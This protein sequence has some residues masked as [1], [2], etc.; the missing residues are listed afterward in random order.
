MNHILMPPI[1]L[2][3]RPGFERGLAGGESR[4]VAMR[5]R[6]VAIVCGLAVVILSQLAGAANGTWNV[7]A[8]GSWTN[9]ANWTPVGTPNGQGQIAALTNN[10][11]NNR[12]VTLDAAITVGTLIVGDNNNTHGFTLNNG[13]APGGLTFDVASGSAVLRKM[14]RAGGTD[15]IGA[16]ITLADNL[17]ATNNVTGSL[18]LNGAIGESAAG[19]SITF[20]GV[21]GS[22]FNLT[23][24]NSYSGGTTVRNNVRLILS[25]SANALGLG[26]ATVLSNGQ[27]WMN[28]ALTFTN[29]LTLNGIGWSEGSGFLGAIRFAA[30]AVAS[31]PVTLGSDVR[32]SAWGAGDAG[33]ISGGIDGGYGLEKTGAG[34]LTL[35]GANTYT[36]G[37][38]IR[39]INS[40]AGTLVLDYTAQNNSKISSTAGM[41]ISNGTLR[42]VGN[43]A[44]YTQ[45]VAGL[46]LEA[47]GYSQIVN[48]NAGTATRIDFTANGG[49]LT[50]GTDALLHMHVA[51]G[52]G[53]VLP[54]T[55]NALL[56][57]W[58]TLSSGDFAYLDANNVVTTPA[59]TSLPSS[60][61]DDATAYD[62]TG[63][64]NV[65]ASET[66]GYLKYA[67]A[68]AGTALTIDAGQTLTLQSGGLAFNGTAG[69]GSIT[70]SGGLTTPADL[71]VATV[72]GANALTID[73][74]IEGA[75]GLAKIG[76]GNL[77][78]SGV[79]TFTGETRA[80][81]GTL[82][83]SS[84]GALQGSTL[85]MAQP[86]L[87]AVTVASDLNLG[88]LTGNRALSG[89][90]F[91]MN[92]GSN[93]ASTVY[94]G[95]LSA[96]SQFTKSG[97]GIL[98]LSGANTYTGITYIA[99]G[100]LK[101]GNN[102]A[103]GGTGTG[104]AI[105]PGA[106]LDIN[107]NRDIR[108]EQIVVSG[109]GVDG[110]GAIVN[111]GGADAQNALKWVT[112]VG[113]TTFGGT[114]RWDIRNSGAV[115]GGTYTLTT[116]MV[117]GRAFVFNTTTVQVGQ[118]NVESGN[119]VI[120]AASWINPDYGISFASNTTFNFY[121]YT[122]S[123]L[124]RAF[125]MTN[126]TFS[127]S[128]STSVDQNWHAGGIT[129][130][131]SNTVTVAND[132]TF[133]S[134]K[135]TGVGSL[136]KI[137]NGTLHIRNVNDY[138]GGTLMHA[139]TVNLY[140]NDA[141]G[142]GDVVVAGGTLNVLRTD[143]LGAAQEV[144]VENRALVSLLPQDGTAV[145][146]D[147]RIGDLGRLY[148]PDAA[149][150]LSSTVFV[151]NRASLVAF[152]N[153][154]QFSTANFSAFLT[155]Y[156]TPES[157][158]AL[159][160]GQTGGDSSTVIDF[161]GTVY[162][163]MFFGAS[164]NV[165]FGGTIV[166]V[167]GKY[168]LG[169]GGQTYGGNT[170][171]TV[172][173]LTGA[174]DVVIG[175]PGI[176]SLTAGDTYS[177][178]TVVSNGGW[179]AMNV[180]GA[181]YFG[182]APGAFAVSNVVFDGGVFRNSAAVSP[183][184][185]PNRQIVLGPG[186]VEFYVWSGGTVTVSSQVTGVGGIL[187]TDGGT[188]VLAGSNSFTGPLVTSNAAAILRLD[189]KDA[190]GGSTSV[191]IWGSGTSGNGN[192]LQLAGNNV[193]GAGATLTMNGMNSLQR[194]ALIG[195]A[196]QTNTWAG[197]I[198]LTGTNYFNH[199][200]PNGGLIIAGN[201]TNDGTGGTGGLFAFRGGGYGEMHGN[202]DL[203]NARLVFTDT[204]TW[205][206]A[207]NGHNY[208]YTRIEGSTVTVLMGADH[209]FG[210]GVVSYGT[211]SGRLASDSDAPRTISNRV[212][213]G[214]TIQL[215]QTSGGTGA[216]TFTGDWNLM[217]GGR[218]IIN[219]TQVTIAGTIASGTTLTKQGAGMLVLTS[220]NSYTG[221]TTLSPASGQG[222]GTIL[223]AANNAL[224][225]NVVT[226][227]FNTG[228]LSAQLQLSNNI[229]LPN[230]FQTS[231]SPAI[232]L[233]RNVHGT[234]ELSGQLEQEGGGGNSTYRADANTMLILS[235]R[236]GAD[237]NAARDLTLSGEGDFLVS[238]FVEDRVTANA[239]DTL[240]LIVA[241]SG[242][243]TVSGSNTYTRPTVVNAGAGT[244]RA[245]HNNAFG[246]GT[247]TLN[248]GRLSST[249]AD[250]RFLANNVTVGGNVAL[251]S[252]TDTGALTLGGTVALGAAK[253]QLTV[254]S[255]VT[256]TNVVSGSA[257]FTKGGA[258][259][260]NLLANNILTGPVDVSN[261]TLRVN[262]TLGGGLITVAAG[263]VLGGT[264]TVG[265][266]TVTGGTLD[267]GNSA[268]LLTAGGAVSLDAASTFA[269]E[270]IAPG[271]YD[272]LEMG[273]F[274]LTL[275]DP[276]LSVSLGYAPGFGD[277]FAIVTGLSGFDPDVF[278]TFHNLAQGAE[279]TVNSTTF[280]IDYGTD[281]ITLTV[282]P[283]PGT[284]GTLMLFLAAAAWRR[285][286]ARN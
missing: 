196:G 77:V 264:G 239:N 16:T 70:G 58:A 197:T 5:K 199:A 122:G 205:R 85:N 3:G 94:S 173:N 83:L 42:I 271:A 189:N 214:S 21:A 137:G 7:D 89:G 230:R 210:T 195:T 97:T 84:P 2:F 88:G 1:D 14:Y 186:G 142:V 225:T 136:T 154:T 175:Q 212:E 44:A 113:D 141:L 159:V 132:L 279:F 276:V 280:E 118:I 266:V 220:P 127:A 182:T 121:R 224:G 15:T 215:G 46:T 102:A 236:I 124:G 115:T 235:G 101:V 244:L 19:K 107:G 145:Q 10:I 172:T 262:G 112:L 33:T 73:A 29:A 34:T 158:G 146:G 227:K 108:N 187:R 43:A 243:V 213:L 53:I 247:L 283:E 138:S 104:T 87:G 24:N 267:P 48:T 202:I 152:S 28:A 167:D 67:P 12:T 62:L 56:G 174:Y 179:V 60:G 55:P 263:G 13:I 63:S 135:V 274:P 110:L 200:F 188:L 38:A 223:A 149:I 150:D 284:F 59:Y 169:G 51:G 155:K 22:Q 157:E 111:N 120:E 260:L 180:T 30:N 40:Q 242:R 45:P 203:D 252:A 170:G 95:V 25:G 129:L 99:E 116:K 6:V 278:G 86:D 206:I 285:R 98:T 54:G 37:T 237:A 257:G 261:G 218:T 228:A 191:A 151:S 123:P 93:G 103:L 50:R 273:T 147:F 148:I 269:V 57:A 109:A 65:T 32:L 105:L 106:T 36:G 219:E 20:A 130:V 193:Y 216:L 194:A 66:A 254:D 162:S 156:V 190:L 143:A 153:A 272:Q 277:S 91:V 259:M 238:G 134:N 253:R 17:L 270:L 92:V 217:N 256:L 164:A 27:L 248:G 75:G 222:H 226:L 232:G 183:V 165:T 160:I 249:G 204:A 52:G 71:I 211:A 64:Q 11:G 80:M 275:A 23:G 128:S 181:D 234:N 268:G 100:T 192:Q 79:S 221:G 140:T 250:A 8:A 90:N 208:T 31:G 139:G 117:P 282:I 47:A 81:Q 96:V 245:G 166:P 178:Q 82:T 177:G 286:L 126:A 125:T 209:P 184:L 171:L 246:S 265:A 133:V 161:S 240:G 35:R 233:I 76:N 78:L 144:T 61:A 39:A 114:N 18:A 198:V 255:A 49:A 185:H 131:D 229:V 119:F 69:A 68:G 41:T 258:G 231:G 72:V 207:T 9:T 201:I 176:V 281:E 168:R 163:N 4:G 74:P 251:G 241:T 26:A